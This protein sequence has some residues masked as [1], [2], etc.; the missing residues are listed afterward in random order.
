M[1]IGLSKTSAAHEHRHADH[2]AGWIVGPRE[3]GV[4]ALTS[5]IVV[6]IV[7]LCVIVAVGI[8]V[9]TNEHAIAE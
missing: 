3:Q 5:P 7:P 2:C 9:C 1:A 4:V 8:L 6:V